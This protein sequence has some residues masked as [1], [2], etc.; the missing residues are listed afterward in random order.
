MEWEDAED[1]RM[2]YVDLDQDGRYDYFFKCLKMCIISVS[3]L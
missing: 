2:F 3:Q 1:L